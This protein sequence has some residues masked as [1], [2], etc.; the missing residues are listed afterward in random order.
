MGCNLL[1][2]PFRNKINVLHKGRFHK[3]VPVRNY[4]HKIQDSFS[5]MDR[6]DQGGGSKSV[7]VA[8]WELFCLKQESGYIGVFFTLY[9][10]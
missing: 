3:T 5:R 8:C 7:S 6:L 9:Y 1:A 4:K 10:L 2:E